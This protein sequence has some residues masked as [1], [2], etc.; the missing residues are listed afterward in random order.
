MA[1]RRKRP[2][3]SSRSISRSSCSVRS[4]WKCGGRTSIQLNETV[5]SVARRCG[6]NAEAL[7]Q[8]NPG[9]GQ[10][11]FGNGGLVTVPRPALPS[12]Q[13]P[14]FGNRGIVTVP[15]PRVDALR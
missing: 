8:A 4:I 10:R 15:S 3:A 6:I 2:A 11:D 5:E 1:L 7:K 13:R 9:I 14:V 12:P